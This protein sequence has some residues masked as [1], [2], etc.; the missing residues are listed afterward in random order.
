MKSLALMSFLL[1]LSSYG[2][3]QHNPTDPDTIDDK[4]ANQ[5][6]W[7]NDTLPSDLIPLRDSVLVAA[8]DIPHKLHKVLRSKDEYGGWEAGKIYFDKP[9]KIY[10]VYIPDVKTTRIYGFTKDGH[11]VSF[12]SFSTQ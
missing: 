11:P 5:E 4:V 6:S 10:K 3:A 9:S 2:Y 12:R 8:E 1:L 7:Y